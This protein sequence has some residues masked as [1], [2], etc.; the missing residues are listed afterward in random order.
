[1]ALG[2]LA[3][4]ALGPSYT[5]CCGT[6]IMA[7]GGNPT[8]E[9]TKAGGCTSIFSQDKI[10]TWVY[11]AC[12]P[13]LAHPHAMSLPLAQVDLPHCSV[14]LACCSLLLMGVLCLSERYP[15]LFAIHA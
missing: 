15:C 4:G 1:M 6:T 10:S 13:E 5:I 2:P 11:F 9:F 3:R 8:P 12:S 7:T 14:F